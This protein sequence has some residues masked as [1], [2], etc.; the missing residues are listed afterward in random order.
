[1]IDG[2]D[3]KYM[4]QWQGEWRAVL[5]MFDGQGYMTTSAMRAVKVVLYISEEHVAVTPVSPGEVLGRTDRDPAQRKWDWI[6][7]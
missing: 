4:M 6:K 2:P 1:M 7:F 3:S 5:V